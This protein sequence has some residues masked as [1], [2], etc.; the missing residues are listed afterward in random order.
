M[1]L[2]A[3]KSVSTF[4]HLQASEGGQDVYKDLEFQKIH[5]VF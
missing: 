3:C 1:F 4:L 5:F 2:W